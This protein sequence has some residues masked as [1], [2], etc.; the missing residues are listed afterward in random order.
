MGQASNRHDLVAHY[1]R[2][3]RDALGSPCPG[4]GG[5]GLALFLRRGMAAWIEAWWE[6]TSPVEPI[7]RSEPHV[8]DPI[9]T[10]TRTQITALLA[11]MIL[12][13]QQEATS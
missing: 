12:C 6:C 7:A 10:D 8:D 1:E 2:L 5:F 13:L 3:R 4:D 9:P 11:G